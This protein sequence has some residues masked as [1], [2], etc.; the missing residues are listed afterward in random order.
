[1]NRLPTSSNVRDGGPEGGLMGSFKVEV[2]HLVDRPFEAALIARTVFIDDVVVERVLMP[3][4]VCAG[5]SI[6]GVQ[7]TAEKLLT[8]C[9]RHGKCQRPMRTLL[10][11]REC[12]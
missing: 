6:H 12:T 9:Y 11:P 1:M 8:D 10:I 2:G 3:V 5:V 7:T 4:S